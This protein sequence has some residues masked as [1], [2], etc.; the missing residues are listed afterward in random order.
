MGGLFGSSKTEKTPTTPVEDQ[1]EAELRNQ[2]MGIAQK[3]LQY[4]DEALASAW[5]TRKDLSSF[6]KKPDYA[7]DALESLVGG[8]LPGAYMKNL[9]DSINYGLKNTMGEAINSLAN[10]GVINSSVTNK[11]TKQMGDSAANAFSQGFNQSMQTAGQIA[12]RP[13]DN[14]YK[15]IYSLNTFMN[16][17]SLV[18]PA[19]D[20]YN[21]WRTTRYSSKDD[22]TTTDS[23]GI[24]D[25]VLGIAKIAMK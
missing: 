2:I 25:G 1:Y 21:L 12:Q 5:N 20:L 8:N 17:Q 18:Q 6:V 9:T 14:Y 24:L 7:S 11:A 10:R 15:G 16:P 23:P 4:Y 13:V 19:E 3:P 22:V